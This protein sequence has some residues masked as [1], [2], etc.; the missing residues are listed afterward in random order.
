M[1]V[2]HSD[3]VVLVTGGGSGIGRAA[4]IA[5]ASC[6]AK[7]VV[8]DIDDKRS[9]ETVH[10]IQEEEGEWVF[11]KTY[12]SI[13]RNVI[14]MVEKQLKCMVDRNMPLTMLAYLDRHYR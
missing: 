14:N 9:S 1:K 13:S 11:I 2:N 6:G 12:V 8:A 7:V 4:S 10:L 5:F 3:K